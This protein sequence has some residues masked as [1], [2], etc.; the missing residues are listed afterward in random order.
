MR[1]GVVFLLV[2]VSINPGMAVPAVD[3]DPP[4]WLLIS[5]LNGL[6]HIESDLTIDYQVNTPEDQQTIVEDIRDNLH[7]A[8]SAKDKDISMPTSEQQ[9]FDRYCVSEVYRYLKG[10]EFQPSE[11]EARRY[12]VEHEEEFRDPDALE[13]ARI[14]I[15]NGTGAQ[16]QAKV[17]KDRLETS[18]LPFREIAKQYYRTLGKEHDGYFGWVRRGTIRDDVFDLFF[19]AD[20]TKSFFGPVDTRH[21][22]LFGKVYHLSP[23]EKIPFRMVKEKIE[24]SLSKQRFGQYENEI[25]RQGQQ[26]GDLRFLVSAKTQQVP[27]L[28]EEVLQVGNRNWTYREILVAY[29]GIY[30][31]VKSPDFFRVMV[32]Q[33]AFDA[34]IYES[35]EARKVRSSDSY[36]FLYSAFMGQWKAFRY[37]QNKYEPIMN[38]EKVL[39]Q[40]YNENR[41]VKYRKPDKIKLIFIQWNC[42]NWTAEMKIQ[43]SK[44]R[45]AFA[46][47]DD[48]TTFSLTDYDLKDHL[49]IYRDANWISL[50]RLNRQMGMDLQKRAKGYTS[51][52]IGESGRLFFYHLLDRTSGGYEAFD[53]IQKRVAFD[54]WLDAK[55][56]FQADL[57]KQRLESTQ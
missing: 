46:A 32:H 9:W 15:E 5:Y 17:L 40:F 18:S 10:I 24:S 37:F 3:Y 25:V 49:T 27:S 45:D 38:D 39:S 53:E 41:E 36:R 28:D 21:G 35:E 42:P 4:K 16:E 20:P 57:R 19:D 22:L 43:M 47:A 31:E 51:K 26:A 14:L 2:L 11:E 33:A 12:W 6:S 8:K 23:G 29:P 50:D 7:F 1:I 44:I 54:Y 30:G 13:G 55:K 48:P 56:R 34:L 52:V